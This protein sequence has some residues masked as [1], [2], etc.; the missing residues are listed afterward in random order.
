MEIKDTLYI[1]KIKD[2]WENKKGKTVQNRAIDIGDSH[3]K[4]VFSDDIEELPSILSKLE[5]EDIGVG[6]DIS[7]DIILKSRQ[8]RMEDF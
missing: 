1:S 2:T 7:I 3:F 5:P 4:I 8:K 6:V